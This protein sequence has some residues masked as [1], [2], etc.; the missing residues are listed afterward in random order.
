MREAI[1]CTSVTTSHIEIIVIYFKSTK[2]ICVM[3]GA[4]HGDTDFNCFFYPIMPLYLAH[5]AGCRAAL[6]LMHPP[7]AP[8]G[9]ERAVAEPRGNL[10]G[11]SFLCFPSSCW[12]V[13]GDIN[14]DSRGL[15]KAVKTQLPFSALEKTQQDAWVVNVSKVQILNF[16]P[17]MAAVLLLHTYEKTHVIWILGPFLCWHLH[18][19]YRVA[20]ATWDL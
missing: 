9:S 13:P 12:H 2:V 16:P 6:W 8:R 20:K 19:Q 4:V 18:C 7:R 11:H 1:S 5:T 15:W 3:D 14:T 10:L 17:K